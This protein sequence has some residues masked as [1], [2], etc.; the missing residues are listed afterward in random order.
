MRLIFWT[1]PCPH[2]HNA[3]DVREKTKKAAIA[4]AMDRWDWTAERAK[5]AVQKMVVEYDDSF[6][7]LDRCLGECSPTGYD[8]TEF[9]WDDGNNCPVKKH[10]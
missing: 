6:D 3:Y 2:D 10:E 9:G 7:L 8:D 4:E 5:W 1:I